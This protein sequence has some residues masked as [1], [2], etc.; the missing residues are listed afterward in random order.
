MSENHFGFREKLSTV[1]AV[2]RVAGR[3]REAM[4]HKNYQARRSALLTALDARNAFNC[5]RWDRVME[6][7]EGL[8][9]PKY[10]KEIVSH[11]LFERFLRFVTEDI[12]VDYES[13]LR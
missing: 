5:A 10:L 7:V 3:A 6:S 4:S 9:L 12:E 8:D 1:D 13:T 2:K 11:Y